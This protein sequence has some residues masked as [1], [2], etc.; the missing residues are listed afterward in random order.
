[1]T[2]GAFSRIALSDNK[3]YLAASGMDTYNFEI[4]INCD[5]EGTGEI[6]YNGSA[7][8]FCNLTEDYFV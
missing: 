5:H 3:K 1:M 6:Y 4:M 2:K 8:L 7:C